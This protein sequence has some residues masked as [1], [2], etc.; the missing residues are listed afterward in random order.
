MVE[1][2][3]QVEQALLPVHGCNAIKVN[4]TTQADCVRDV[5]S[6]SLSPRRRQDLHSQEW[7]CYRRF[8][9]PEIAQVLL[10]VHACNATTVKATIAAS[11]ESA[12]GRGASPL[13]LS[14]T[15]TQL[16]RTPP[17]LP[18]PKKPQ[19]RKTQAAY[20]PR[21]SVAQALLPVLVEALSRTK[22]QAGVL[23]AH[24]FPAPPNS[25]ATTPVITFIRFVAWGAETSHGPWSPH[26][27]ALRQP[28]LVRTSIVVLL[29]SPEALAAGDPPQRSP[30]SRSH[31][32]V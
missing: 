29:Q 21:S 8:P 10:V 23:A 32:S 1:R 9:A 6:V 16:H 2:R 4:T 27:L 11:T 19:S 15:E 25:A 13:A 18:R 30:L 12:P 24:T 14:R 28:W 26:R 5:P 31:L 3:A 17:P 22:R 20:H 7:L